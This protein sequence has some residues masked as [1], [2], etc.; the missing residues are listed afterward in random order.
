MTKAGSFPALQLLDDKV[1]FV[2][3]AMALP[4][5]V[6]ASRTDLAWHL[7]ASFSVRTRVG[8]SLSTVFPLPLPYV[9]VFDGGGP[10]LSKVRLRTLAQK[11][12]LNLVV[13][14]LNKLY[15][16]RFA[17]VAEL[18]RPPSAVQLK[19]FDRLYGYIT[20]CG[21]RL[22]EFSVAPGR[23]G[24]ELIACIA[25]LEAFLAI[26]PALQ[27]GYFDH[28]AIAYKPPTLSVEEYPQLVP[29]KNLDAKRLKLTGTGAWPLADYLDGE[30]WLPYVEPAFLLHGGP[31]DRTNW[32]SFA[33]EAPEQYFDLAMKWD[34]LGLLRLFDSP[35]Q[36]GHFCKVFNAYKDVDVD[37]QIGDR[38]IPNS[39]E[40]GSPGPSAF[41][42]SAV[43]LCAL[44]VPRGSHSARC[45]MTDRRGFYHQ[46]SVSR[47]RARSNITPFAFPAKRF[48]G[49][50][51]FE[52]WKTEL[53]GRKALTREDKGDF[54]RGDPSERQ[55]SALNDSCLLY[56][57]FG[58]LYQGDHLGVEFALRAHEV[59]LHRNGL[60][61]D[62]RRLQNKHPLPCGSVWE[63]LIID[64]YFC[65][66][67]QRHDV[68]KECTDAFAALQV[69]RHIYEKHD[70][71]GSHEKD[72]VAED[73]FKAAGA[74]VDSRRE[75]IDEGC[76][77]AAAPLGKR[78][79][80]ASLS[81][82]VASLRAISSSLAS[83]LSGSWV[84][85]LLFR[86]CFSSIVQ[87][88]YSFGAACS[89]VESDKVLPLSRAVSQELVELS[90]MA[91]LIS[92]D[93]TRPFDDL[94]FATDASISKGAVVSAP[95]G[96][97]L[98]GVLW[99]GGDKRGGYTRLDNPFRAALKHLGEDL[100][101]EEDLDESAPTIRRA[102]LLV[103]DFVEICGGAGRVSEEMASL[104]YSVAPVL[105]LSESEAYDLK[106]LRLLEWILHMIEQ[107]LF[108]S[109]MVSPPCT[110]F[111][112]AAYPA[113]RSY[114][115]PKG[116]KRRRPKVLIGN[117][118]AFRSLVIMG[119]AYSWGRPSALEQPRRSKMA[120][121]DEW[122]ALLRRGLE[123]AV[124]AS[125]AFGSIHQKEFRLLLAHLDAAALTVHCS[126]DHP[127]VKIEGQYT[128]KSAIY[129]P[130]VAKHFA[131]AFHAALSKL[132][133]DCSEVGDGLES[134]VANDL[135]LASSWTVER[136]WHWKKG[137]HI[138][139]LEVGAVVSLLK[140]A[141]IS[142]SD[143]RLNILLDSNVAK[144]ALAKG[145]SSSKML[146]PVLMKAAALQ[147]A[148]GL[149]PSYNFAPTRL[150]TA[151]HPTRDRR[152]PDPVPHSLVESLSLLQIG[153]LQ[154]RGFSRGA[155]GWIRL[156]L[157][158]IYVL[159]SCGLMPHDFARGE[160]L[161]C[162]GLCGLSSAWIWP[163]AWIS[164][165]GLLGFCG[166][167]TGWTWPVSSLCSLSL[168][169]CITLLLLLILLVTSLS[170]PPLAG[171]R[172]GLVPK[173]GRLKT[174]VGRPR[175]AISAMVW[176][177]LFVGA[178]APLAPQTGNERSRALARATTQL[179]PD[180]TVTTET[181][182]RR[183]IYLK[184]FDAWLNEAMDLSVDVLLAEK[185]A[186]PEKISEC[187][188]QYG[189]A[190]FTAGKSYQKYSETINAVGTARPL[191]KRQLTR[192]WDLAFAW[193]QDEPHSHHPAL[194]ASI[195]LSMLSTALIWGWK[196]EAA[197]WAMGW[198]GIMRVGE[199]LMTRRSDL[200]LPS[201]AAPGFTHIL[202]KIHQ[203]KTRGRGAKH[204][205][206]RVDQEDL[207]RL[208]AGAFKDE[209]ADALL[210]P[211]SA[212]TLRKRFGAV[213]KEL[214]LPTRREGEQRPYELAS[215]RAGGATWLLG[216]TESPDLVRRRGRWQAMR[217]CEIYLQ[218]I[219]VATSLPLLPTQV[220]EKIQVMAASFDIVL[221]R[222]CF[223]M[224]CGVPCNAWYILFCKHS[225]Q[226]Q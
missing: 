122:R 13:L 215:L 222:A 7:R 9:G 46:A 181:R 78:L 100:Y 36:E 95:I 190:L 37:R 70:F 159:P 66:S 80:L 194:P 221:D 56:P 212:S 54:L 33:Y 18:G 3:W 123:E 74:E 25:R 198:S 191:I 162:D 188:V 101:D 55:D 156:S 67:V 8:C 183:A 53:S 59:L 182:D 226:R 213:L 139:V 157:L 64:D 199:M 167:H 76:I 86:R 69:A 168:H 185:P 155:S 214:G 94:V 28:G 201:D 119:H 173:G 108:R 19:V 193:L 26:H 63:A 52:M 117:I 158:V 6:L 58:A 50:R 138:N 109:L 160:G 115:V 132:P 93:L 211:L 118:L 48:L 90:I 164:E 23:S 113:V 65:I 205:A 79:G 68:P 31:D 203:P 136:S 71:A 29:Y 14:V 97:E 144:C 177:C 61:V 124:V 24:P 43:Q 111:S 192:A 11:R 143:R 21:S 72:I 175:L 75:A 129:E 210:W 12:L 223:F 189:R 60:L 85:V 30:L 171:G 172:L 81:L 20:V 110:T 133:E 197:L 184:D 116:W 224:S 142:R 134:I 220:N 1:N 16:G 204:Q 57:A 195:L 103:F 77:P 145:R 104:G 170:L 161:C 34:S 98:A 42:P 208:I 217:T 32:P 121:L 120:W 106:D 82:R 146:T 206:A 218:E 196:R 137:G 84:S 112:P 174:R 5:L 44:Y 135:L 165:S 40:R 148:G 73:L 91:P 105:D 180:R 187:L 22:E 51:A 154:N 147:I 141:V 2:Q 178:G 15:L 47:S 169:G 96:S 126:R 216:M 153:S 39:R 27:G 83:R 179:I 107:N 209:A 200:I 89:E 88:F 202:V 140:D 131:G 62:E 92:S 102:P 49:T 10:G 125:C 45:S 149:Y 186:D 99:R 41:L 163:R 130:G 150:N 219:A 152:L 176:T 151:D 166:L 207:V 87:Q 17:S 38:R 127:H 114:K 35:S 225:S 128:K 4:R